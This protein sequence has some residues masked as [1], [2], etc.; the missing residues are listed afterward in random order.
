MIRKNL[1]VGEPPF[2]SKI[3]LW[4]GE[5]VTGTVVDPQGAPLTGVKVSIYSATSQSKEFLRGAW[6]ETVTDAEGRFRIVPATPGDG[7]LWIKPDNLS[8]QAHR[9]GDR[10]GDWGQITL[11]KGPDVAGRVLD[12]QGAPVAGVRIEAR[13]KGDG[14]KPDEFLNQ[15]AVAGQIG[16]KVVVGSDGAFTLASLPDGEYSLDVEANRSEDNYDPPPLE[17][18]FLRQ[19]I[20]IAGGAAPGPLEIRAVPHVVIQGTYLNSAGRP[21]TGSEVTLFGRVDGGFYYTRSNSPGEDGK[22]ELRVP[23]GLE[24]AELDLI[25]N[26]HSALR[27]RLKHDQPLQRGRRIKLGTLEDDVSGF[28]VVRYVAP[29]LLVKVLDENGQLVRD[30]KP[31]L[32]YTQPPPENGQSLVFTT[33]RDVNFEEQPDGRFRSSQ[34]VPDEPFTV[35]IDRPGYTTTPSEGL[36]LAEG[37]QREVVFT[38]KPDPAAGGVKDDTEKPS[39]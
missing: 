14:E 38:V 5:A 27:W 37:A 26:E 25:T 34:L 13:R 36:S 17:Q 15:N 24:Q 2:Y 3:P 19:V 30:F 6:D 20:T 11:A 9:L 31:V 32:K 33:G 4:P 35:T 8:P 28:E 16:R 7:V 39:P 10:R 1:T 18:V 21:R 23:H 12:V 22:F 29:I